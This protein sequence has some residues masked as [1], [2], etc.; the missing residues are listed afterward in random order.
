MK[1]SKACRGIKAYS[2]YR[3]YKL[4][5][6]AAA[7]AVLAP[8]VSA[9]WN[10]V[11]HGIPVVTTGHFQTKIVEEYQPPEKIFPSDLIS[12][13]VYVQNT[14]A[15]DA[16]VR[17]RLEK[18]FGSLEPDGSFSE[19]TSLDPDRIEI[20]FNHSGLWKEI[21]G[22]Y[23]YTRVLSPGEQ[24]AEPLM[25]AFRLSD[26]TSNQYQDCTGRIVV[27]MESVQ[28]GADAV[29]LW[30]IE[31][32]EL[33][34]GYEDHP[35]ESVTSVEFN[36][37]SAGFVFHPE[38][39]DLFSSFKKLLPGSARSQIIKISNHCKETV[40]IRLHAENA[41]QA[42]MPEEKA[43]L[44]DQIL[45]RY[46]RIEIKQGNETLYEG[47]IDGNLQHQ[48]DA[49]SMRT[50]I[51]LGRFAPGEEKDLAVTLSVSPDLDNRYMDLMGKIH[52][53]FQAEDTRSDYPYT[54][55][56]T[57]IAGWILLLLISM[58]MS[59]FVLKLIRRPAD[60]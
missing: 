25:E 22:Y 9:A 21:G 32:E 49:A 11:G 17:I 58:I 1:R 44:V 48:D 38:T 35:Q 45:S 57:P 47:S 5:L 41:A 46:A 13:K 59:V 60:G 15:A 8:V 4:I 18:Q 6:T 33:G 52:W 23:Y 36:G 7:A 12:K 55:D 31:K 2:A 54:G 19:N 56:L 39:T 16:I 37:R 28:A 42:S 20:Q 10:S 14:G 43:Q 34:I 51:D 3:R 26:E 53:V 30:G 50:P 29:R 27:Y 24:T 40:K